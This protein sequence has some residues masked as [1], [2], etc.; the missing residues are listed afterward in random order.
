M[1]QIE[2]DTEEYRRKAAR[3]P[4]HRPKIL[5]RQSVEAMA[6]SCATPGGKPDPV[7]CPSGPIQS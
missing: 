4:Y 6:A 2:E 3:R 5:S 7:M 1:A